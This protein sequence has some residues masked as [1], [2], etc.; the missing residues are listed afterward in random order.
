[1]CA[2]RGYVWS[3]VNLINVPIIHISP[4]CIANTAP[5]FALLDGQGLAD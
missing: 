4:H 5:R 2:G 1:M 3:R